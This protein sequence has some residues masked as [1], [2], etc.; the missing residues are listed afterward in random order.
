[1]TRHTLTFAIEAPSIQKATALRDKLAEAL[2]GD[3]DVTLLNKAVAQDTQSYR[4]LGVDTSAKAAFDEV[5]EAADEDAAR[6]EIVGSS[7]TKIVAQ[8]FRVLP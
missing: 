1:M 5:V 2:T 8:V 6:A 4:V 7:T 3:E